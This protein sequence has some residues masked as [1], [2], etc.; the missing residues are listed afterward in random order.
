MNYWTL[1]DDAMLIEYH[2]QGMVYAAIGRLLGRS[3]NSCISRSRIL[4][5]APRATAK[6]PEPL[7]RR[8]TNQSAVVQKSSH[9]VPLPEWKGERG[10]FIMELRNDSCRWP[11]KDKPVTYCG[12]RA[13]DNKSY[14]TVHYKLAYQNTGKVKSESV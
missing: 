1:E 10:I 8:V 12:C 3:K 14:C 13:M 9:S 11:S 4:K 5:L 6:H 7:D 2:S